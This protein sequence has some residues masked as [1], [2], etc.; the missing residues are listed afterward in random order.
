VWT[1]KTPSFAGGFLDQNE[2]PPNGAEWH[3]NC[4]IV[5]VKRTQVGE[6]YTFTDV[7]G[8]SAVRIT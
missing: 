3:P 8:G 5:H 1:R 4:T 7:I 6:P 2:R